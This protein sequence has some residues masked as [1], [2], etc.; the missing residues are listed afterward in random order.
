MTPAGALLGW[1]T[2]REA[3]NAFFRIER[4]RNALAFEP[5]GT[6]PSL[7]SGGTS[8]SPLT[9]AFT[10][11]QPLPGINYY[12]LVQT[13]HDG[14]RNTSRI[15]ALSMELADPVI[16]PN[17]LGAAGEAVM[18]PP[19]TFTTY[20]LTDLLGRVVQR[21]DVPGVLSR[22]SLAGLSAGVY[23]LRVQTESGQR[24]F[25]LVR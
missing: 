7:A 25:R 18:D 12:R 23:L 15:I 19:L 10:D 8:L 20:E 9:Y 4:A 24:V 13:D 21:A 14:T 22:V 3:N 16:Y 2:A 5:V 11:T 1:Q 6:V 17:P